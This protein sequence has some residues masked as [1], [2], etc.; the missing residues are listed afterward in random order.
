MG[1]KDIEK[2][3]T[4]LKNLPKQNAPEDF[5]QKLLMRINLYESQKSS[6]EMSFR[7]I[8]VNYFSPIYV[9]AFTIVLVAVLIVYTL[10]RNQFKINSIETPIEKAIPV[11][12][13]EQSVAKDEPQKISVPKKRNYV[14]KRD[15][16]KLNLGPGVNLDERM[17]Y[18]DIESTTPSL[19]S[20]P[21]TDEPVTIRIPPPEVI[22]KNELERLNNFNNYKDS[23]RLINSRRR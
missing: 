1:T 18:E 11:V 14:V 5:E 7:R 22:F 19:V 12:Q 3:L 10:N 15:R 6:G 8:F 17:N 20:F 9:P 23:I 4:D 16:L 21:I 13:D 2:L